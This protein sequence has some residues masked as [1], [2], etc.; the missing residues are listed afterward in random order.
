MKKALSSIDINVLIESWQ[1]LCDSKL[2]QISRH[3]KQEVILKIRSKEHGTHRLLINLDGWIY[4]TNSKGFQSKSGNFIDILKK[5]IKGGRVNSISQINCDRLISIII[6]NNNQEFNLIIELFRKGNLIL[7]KDKEII[8]IL[9]KEKLNDRLLDKGAIYTYPQHPFNFLDSDTAS[10]TEKLKSSHRKLI[11]ALVTDCNLGPDIAEYISS[12]YNPNIA[13]SDLSDE[14]ISS[15]ISHAKSILSNPSKARIYSNNKYTFFATPFELKDLEVN[16]EFSNYNE[17][18]EH[19]LSLKKE[20]KTEE[21]REDGRIFTQKKYLKKFLKQS[22]EMRKIAKSISDNVL[23]IQNLID[24]FNNEKENKEILDYNNTRSEFRTS[25]DDLSFK[26]IPTKSPEA[27]ASLYFKNAK[28]LEAKAAKAEKLILTQSKTKKKISKVKSSISKNQEWFE[29]FRWF[30]TSEGE[31][32]VAGKDARSNDLIV[33]KYLKKNDYF[34]HADIHGAPSVV[35]KHITSEMSEKSLEECGSFS[36]SFSK[37][38]ASKVSGGHA[39]SVIAD[40]VSK[41]PNTGEFLA[42]GSFALRGRRKWF[43]NLPVLLAI[44]KISYLDS[45]KIMI[46][47]VSSLATHSKNYSV[48]RPGFGS[49]AAFS[50][51]LSKHLNCTQEEIQSLLPFGTLDVVESVGF[52]IDNSLL[53]SDE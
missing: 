14:D 44:G 41:T 46:G 16:S 15:I 32:A 36:L 3:S 38:W 25:I 20:V 9:R 42:R 28:S 45:E 4:L 50:Q 2:E 26:I 24:D 5:T 52:S 21:P 1:F 27:N 10:S 33:K 35:V 39:Y 51:L 11:S 22:K 7:C 6:S 43:K 8:S 18:I 48:I 23:F 29:K 17:A 47:P 12:S 30:I 19:L 40:K 37:A 13:I 49:S 53:N 31:I 34:S